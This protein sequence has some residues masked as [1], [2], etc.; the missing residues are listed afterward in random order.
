MSLL[1]RLWANQRLRKWQGLVAKV[2]AQDAAYRSL[3]DGQLHKASLSLRYQVLSGVPANKLLVQAFGIVRQAATRTL[4]MTHYPV[5]ILGGI[6]LHHGAIAV[7]QTG[8]GKTLTATLPLYLA[9]LTQQGAHLVTAN[10]YLAERDAALM[11]PLFELLG[12]RVGVA[13]SESS[14]EERQQAYAADITYSTAKEIGF[15]FLRD[16]IATRQSQEVPNLVGGSAV[17]T[18][19][20]SAVVQREFNFALIDEADSILIDEART[21]LIVSAPLPDSE[22]PRAS[23]YRWAAASTNAFQVDTDFVQEVQHRRITLTSAGRRK[24]RQLPRG[25]DLATVPLLE[26][27][28]FIEQ[29]LT[30][31]QYFQ[32]G[33]QYLIKENEVQIVDEFTGR[34]ADGR[35]WRSGLHQAIE[36]R[37]GVKISHETG[38]AARVTVQDLFL[39]YPRLAGMTGT[40]AASGPELR[41]IYKLWPVEI[42][43]NRPPKRSRLPDRVCQTAEQKWDEIA[44]EVERV[45]CTGRPVLVGTRSIELSRRLSDRLRAR[46]ISHHV[47]NAT[48]AAAEA[49]IVAQAGQLGAVTVATNMAGRGTDVKL[50]LEAFDVGGLHVICSELHESARIDRQLIGR[51]GRQGDPGSYQHFHC[52]EDDVLIAGFGKRAEAWRAAVRKGTLVRGD[53][54]VFRQAQRKVERRHFKARRQLLF[55]EGH[56]QQLQR[57]MGQDPYLDTIES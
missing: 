53:V 21:P 2:Q 52:W 34:V 49:Q 43:T 55:M 27:Y 4:G 6:A 42:P 38:E 14:F 26:L 20:R 1:R 24:T 19:D 17:Y 51:C 50:S 35:K 33:R 13:T 28:Q 11:R 9:A 44:A 30:V 32:D 22:N 25:R 39:R 57:E 46:Q 37:H 3:D 29:A 41:S 31:A 5:Q 10:D 8:E 40:V 16:R 56:R 48:N 23:L 12:M 15:D 36:A 45:H 54:S 47:L 18:S 7:M